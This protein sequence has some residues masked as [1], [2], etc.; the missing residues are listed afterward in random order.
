M[1][2]PAISVSLAGLPKPNGAR[3]RS[4]ACAAAIATSA[5]A[6]SAPPLSRDLDIAHF[7][8]RFDRPG[9]DGIVVIDRACATDRA[10]FAIRRLH[11]TRLVDHA[12]LQQRRCAVPDPIT[13]KTR[14]RLAMHRLLQPRG[15][16]VAATVGGDVDAAYAAPARPCQTADLVVPAVEDHLPARRRCDD[17]LGF[18]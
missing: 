7:A 15:A 6:I 14:Q 5:H 18:L 9:L 3:A 13:A 1:S 4:A 2:Q 8:R 10:Q 11:I 12:G 16:P 17:A